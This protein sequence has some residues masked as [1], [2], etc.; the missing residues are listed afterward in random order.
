MTILYEGTAIIYRHLNSI[1]G[2]TARGT[3]I[4]ARM[5]SYRNLHRNESI[6][7]FYNGNSDEVLPHESNANDMTRIR[8]DIV[9]PSNSSETEAHIMTQ[10]ED[11][12]HIQ[13]CS[14]ISGDTL[15]ALKI[16]GTVK[17]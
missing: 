16:Y 9:S 10:D 2:F 3:N 14:D 15:N 12:P 1:Q 17:K 6:S 11:T 7:S 13:F 4:N 5:V 8:R